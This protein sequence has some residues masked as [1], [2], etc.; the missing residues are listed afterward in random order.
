MLLSFLKHDSPAW[1]TAPGMKVTAGDRGQGGGP[2]QLSTADTQKCQTPL[3]PE[4]QEAS[5]PLGKSPAHLSLFSSC[6][7]FPDSHSAASPGSRSLPGRFHLPNYEGQY[8]FPD[9]QV[10]CSAMY[11]GYNHTV[12]LQSKWLE[13]LAKANT[14][15]FSNSASWLDGSHDRDSIALAKRGVTCMVFRVPASPR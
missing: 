15:S 5:W 1:M 13:D 10:P 9:S 3:V 7:T 2:P 11:E 14:C 8:I 4:V 6:G 12:C